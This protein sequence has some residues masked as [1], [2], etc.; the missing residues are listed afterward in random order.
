MSD[1]RTAAVLFADAVGFSRRAAENE[2]AALATLRG[3]LELIELTVGLNG[4]RVVKTIGDG[5]MAEFASA[6]RAVSAGAAIQTRLAERSRDL[7]GANDFDFRVGIHAGEMVVNGTDLLGDTVNIAAR[8]ESEAPAGGVLVSARVRDEVA[9]RLDLTFVHRGERRLHNM[10]LPMQVFEIAGLGP[11][12]PA[13]EIPDGLPEKPS[14]AVLPFA[15]LTGDEGQ[16]YFVDGLAEDLITALAH[17]P[18]V[19]VIARNSSF[20][21]R[22]AQMDVSQIG[23]DLGVR[24][25]VEGSVQRSAEQLRVSARLVEA[26]TGAHIWADRLEGS[27]QDIFDFQDRVAEAV[28][29][30]ITPEIRSAEIRRSR[31]KQATSL[32]AYDRFLRALSALNRARV[33]EAVGWLDAAL[34]EQPGFARA[35]ALRAWCHTLE[36]SWAGSAER[37]RHFDAGPLRA[38]EALERGDDDPEV[39]ALA[40]YALAFFGPNVERG[41]ELVRD[42]GIRSPSFAWAH[43][44]LALL[45][46]LKGEP[47]R[48]FA[49]CDLA[50]R[51]SPRDP[52]IFRVHLARGWA[53]R[54]MGEID[55]MLQEAEKAHALNANLMPINTML[56]QGFWVQGRHDRAREAA[57]EFMARF[58]DFT[59]SGFAGLHRRLGSIDRIGQSTL[60]ALEQSG[61][62]MGA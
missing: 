9:D 16:G 47:E 26:E 58:P 17:V 38:N 27:T 56:I 4:G 33:D 61:V 37:D 8:L 21:F 62:P 52:M 20:A 55:R 31:R 35:L 53:W 30:A 1:R 46:S 18:W 60:S 22:G 54:A 23:R 24:Y 45:E 7:R 14:I 41:M 32:T 19:F 36:V 59:I 10:P 50:V 34:A 2:D 42:A 29:G 48:A 6:V 49:P 5:L 3:Q 57:R 13:P 44:S 40:G 39:N 25:L 12:A 28:I 15:N 11:V 43:T 51:C